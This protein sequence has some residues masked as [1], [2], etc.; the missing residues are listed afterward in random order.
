MDLVD[1]A[2]LKE[3]EIHEKFQE[4]IVAQEEPQTS[5]DFDKVFGIFKSGY[6]ANEQPTG[7]QATHYLK[8]NNET[9]AKVRPDEPVFILRG[10]DVTAPSTILDWIKRN[11]DTVPETKLKEAFHTVLAMRRYHSRRDPT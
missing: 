11:L 10:Q 8:E 7:N 1:L 3:K 9:W 4:W 5:E 2:Q 6:I